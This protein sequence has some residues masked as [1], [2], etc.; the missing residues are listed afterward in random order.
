MHPNKS[1]RS[2]DMH[3]YQTCI[4]DRLNIADILNWRSYIVNVLTIVTIIMDLIPPLIDAT[5]EDL[6]LGLAQGC[7]TSVDLVEVRKMSADLCIV[8]FV[9]S[10]LPES[11]ESIMLCMR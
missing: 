2:S 10:M 3:H 1:K 4:V 5:S 6:L 11:A 8:E 7:Y 9:R